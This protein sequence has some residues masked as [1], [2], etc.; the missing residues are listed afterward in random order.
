[1]VVLGQVA[2]AIEL[3]PAA[4]VQVR[5]GVGN[6]IAKLKAGESVKIAYLGGSISEMDGWRRLSREWLQTQ[7]P[8]SSIGEIAAAIGGTGSGL[9]VYR[10]GQDVLA[11]NPD[12]LFVEF[13]TN[14]ASTA[15][16]SIWKAFD[17]IVRQTWRHNPKTDIVFVY[18]ITA[19]MVG[20]YAVGRYPQAASAMEMLAEYYG[21]PSICFGLRVAADATAGTLVMN[22]GETATPVPVENQANDEAL[23]DWYAT[24]QG[25]RL[26]SKDGVHPILRAHRCYYLESIKAAWS[27][28]E[29]S[30]VAGSHAAKLEVAYYDATYESAKLVTI[31][32]VMLS[33]NW[34]QVE[35]N[36]RNGDFATRFGGKPWLAT[37]PGAK[38][39]F[40]FKGRAC[41]IYGLIGPDCGQ[42]K[43][44]VDGVYRQTTPLFDSYCS[45][46]RLS[47]PLAWSGSDGVHEVE[48]ELDSV[49]PSRTAVAESATNPAKYDGTTWYAGKLMILGELDMAERFDPSTGVRGVVDLPLLGVSSCGFST[50]I[51]L[52]ASS[53][54]AAYAQWQVDI[55]AVFD[56]EQRK[57]DALFYLKD[58]ADGGIWK[59]IPVSV[60]VEAGQELHLLAQTDNAFGQIVA[61][62]DRLECGVIGQSV[63]GDGTRVEVEL[64]LYEIDGNGGRSGRFIVP[65]SFSRVLSAARDI[66]RGSWFDARIEQ[67]EK[68]PWDDVLAWGGAWDSSAEMQATLA[69][70]GSLM[71]ESEGME[72]DFH[73]DQSKLIGDGIRSV[74]I[75]SSLDFEEYAP[76]NLP[77]IDPSWKGGMLVVREKTNELKYYGVVKDGSVNA[78]KPLSG[79]PVRTDGQVAAFQMTLKLSGAELAITY[80]VDGVDCT[81]DGQTEIPIVGLRSVS[82]VVFGGNGMIRSLA[83][84]F[85]PLKKGLI[86]VID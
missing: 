46:Y 34:R 45:Y 32:P 44:T 64:R 5:K 63:Q 60:P 74:T 21:I 10:V 49:Q 29:K 86:V 58:G 38:I 43:M 84:Q 41:Y 65:A 22:H 27:E 72:I 30:A 69:E 19:P 79:P 16:T 70:R 52:S 23:A 53:D 9:G 17:G 77:K 50:A 85:E 20:D 18:T 26:F 11:H 57:D 3:L 24:N 83:A 80:R 36:E 71:L 51:D 78:W 28:L 61:K 54:Y 37:V 6:F 42:C 75:V 13:A 73:A 2:S 7:Y 48:V 33:G 76:E 39:K 81:Y 15:P 31:D 55:V 40:R 66:V 47:Y 14:D 62:T 82:D 67:Y 4:E 8:S 1:M 68:W 56:R 35:A 12:L 59:K 25:K